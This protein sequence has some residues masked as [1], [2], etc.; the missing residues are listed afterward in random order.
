MPSRMKSSRCRST[1]FSAYFRHSRR[2]SRRR[3]LRLLRS[4][5]AIDFDLDRQPV[6][7]PARGRMANRNPAIV[8]D[9]T[10]KSFSILL[11]ACPRWILPFA[12][13]GPSCRTYFGRPARELANL[14]IDI[15]CCHFSSRLRLD[16][17]ADWPSSGSPSWA[18]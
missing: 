12:Y 9:L 10:M 2:M 17:A 1:Y 15:P 16:S 8:F 4:E 13:G 3:H 11:N 7:V 18:D 5:L 14:S 6:A